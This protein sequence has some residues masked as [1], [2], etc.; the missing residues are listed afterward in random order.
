[1]KNHNVLFTLVL[2]A[3]FS[4]A[5]TSTQ[6]FEWSLSSPKDKI[7]TGMY[8]AYQGFKKIASGVTDA[9]REAFNQGASAT[10]LTYAWQNNK[11]LT[12]L[13]LAA[14]TALAC[15]GV[16]RYGKSRGKKEMAHSIARSIENEESECHYL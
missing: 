5:T 1:M 15:W 9:V 12:A 10:G 16:Y 3:L 11:E 2:V 4:F 8:D 7:T 14:A 6:A 13:G